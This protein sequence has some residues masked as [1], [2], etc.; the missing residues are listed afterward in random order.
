MITTKEV[1]NAQNAW[2]EGVVKIGGLKD[3]R[4][5]CESYSKEF[6]DKHYD[7]QNKEVLFKPTKTSVRQFRPTKE[8][9]LSYFIG[10]N[11]EYPEDKGFALQPWTKVRFENAALILEENR[12]LAMGNYFFTDLNGGETK[13]EF[14]FGYTKD[15]NGK[16]RIDL[17]H[18]SLPFNP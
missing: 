17:H 11:A 2:G 1:E 18:S 9:A 15:E 5:Q 8:G 7:F 10:G 4:G 14:T 13:V 3:Q 16:L 12:A 6:I